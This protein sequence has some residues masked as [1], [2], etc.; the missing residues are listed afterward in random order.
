MTCR[1]IP[2]LLL[3]CAWI[4]PATAVEF[5]DYQIGRDLSAGEAKSLEQR[6]EHDPEDTEARTHLIIYYGH[7]PADQEAQRV[8]REHVVWLIRN[9]P[10]AG[11]LAE[12]WAQ[13]HPHLDRDSYAAG[14][15][16]WLSHVQRE[17]KDVTY[18][19]HATNFLS[20][21]EDRD[22]VVTY[23]QEIQ[24][25]DPDNP[26][27][28]ADLGH[29]YQRETNRN[30]SN[31]TKAM[32]ALALLQRAHELSRDE[33]ER[34]FLLPDLA[35]A[36]LAAGRH[37]DA[38]RYATTL[39]DY[40]GHRFFE[41]ESTHHGNLI[42]GRVALIEDDDERAKRHLLRA[43]RTPGSPALNSFGPNMGLA[44]EL[45]ERNEREV[46]LEYFDLCSKFWQ[47]SELEDWAAIVEA[48]G[49]P[50]F[51]ANLYY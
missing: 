26:R 10:Q 11:V 36:A 3:L 30:P 50:D 6:L 14:K 46:V 49:I 42:L 16:A 9:A 37:D 38:R 12:P 5:R 15:D 39:L 23:L 44:L 1:L 28:P 34:L 32:Q 41:G 40:S 19:S 35:K 4:V 2:C 17:P 27:W 21:K 25:L 8:R 31:T 7:A 47:R 20:Q 45:L 13:I 29:L 51:G 18:L 43:G 33:T 22:L 24:R 48:G